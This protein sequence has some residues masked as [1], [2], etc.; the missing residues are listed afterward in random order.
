[1]TIPVEITWTRLL[2]PTPFQIPTYWIWHFNYEIVSPQGPSSTWQSSRC[3]QPPAW[4][5]RIRFLMAFL[6][7]NCSQQSTHL[8]LFLHILILLMCWFMSCGS[9]KN[10]GAQ[11]A[12]NEH[13]NWK[14][15]WENTVSELRSAAENKALSDV[16]WHV[17]ASVL[18]LIWLSAKGVVCWYFWNKR[19]INNKVAQAATEMRKLTTMWKEWMAKKSTCERSAW[20]DVTFSASILIVCTASFY[21]MLQTKN[22]ITEKFSYFKS[23]TVVDV[24]LVKMCL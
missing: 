18:V 5:F 3:A 10:F 15:R 14:K 2:Q 23:G 12:T 1:M 19:F 9:R 21:E 11:E 17:F 6:E 22:I 8:H 4:S 16:K 7:S 24:Q 13:L 20:R